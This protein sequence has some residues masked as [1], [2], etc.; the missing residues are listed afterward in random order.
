[1]T[2]AEVMPRLLLALPLA[3]AVCRA[4]G[5]AARRLGQ[6]PVVGEIAVGVLIGPSLLGGERSDAQS[7]LLP[8][9]V[10][11][12]IEVLG[13]VGLLTF[14]F[15]TG[16][17]LDL[18]HLRGHGRAAVAVSQAG[19]LVPLLLGGSLGLALYGPLAPEG[20]ERSTFTLFV[21]VAMSITA[22]PVLARILTDR[23]LY[24]SPLGSLAMACAAVDDIT[25]WCLLALVV[26]VSRGGTPLD[27]LTAA[28][29]VLLYA[30]VMLRLV[31]PLLE[32]ALRSRPAP[33]VLVWL[34]CGM[35][36]SSVV[37][38]M[39]GVH[40]LFGAFTF[41]V[42][43]P[44]GSETVEKA[45]GALRSV[46]VPLLLPLFFLVAGLHADVGVLAADPAQWL[47]LGAILIVALAGKWGGA[48][49]AAR[50]SGLPWRQALALGALMNCRGLTE[51][52]VLTVG[53]D[54]GVISR[55]LFTMLV[56]MALLTTAITSP[57][58]AAFGY[59]SHPRNRSTGTTSTPCDTPEEVGEPPLPDDTIRSG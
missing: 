38:D 2:V 1:M 21:A 45:V 22:F 10:L 58:V 29:L 8:P 5:A 34:F 35:C 28:A 40:A 41:G 37:T 14:M 36:L 15:L 50:L 49:A 59:G 20:V 3:I 23:G 12:H 6:P 31:R 53:L 30:A 56:L 42:V 17:T 46:V 24:Q 4:G 55:E 54:L 43:T 9:T 18:R 25:A 57:A 33:V 44:R 26:A 13:Q 39:I 32:K 48:A 11:N 47:W 16:L 52:I 19:I 27:S 7:Y 51:L